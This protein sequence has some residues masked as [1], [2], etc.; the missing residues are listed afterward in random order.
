MSRMRNEAAMLWLRL[1][2]LLSPWLLMRELLLLLLMSMRIVSANA[3]N[4]HRGR[5]SRHAVKAC[6]LLRVLR[7]LCVRLRS[8]V[9]RRSGHRVGINRLGAHWH[10]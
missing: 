7:V 10:R 2:L 5:P 6:R 4:L 3:V 9:V 8:N 1:L